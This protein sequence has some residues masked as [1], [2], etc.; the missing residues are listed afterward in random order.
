MFR[1]TSPRPLRPTVGNTVGLS[2][3][4]SNSYPISVAWTPRHR[5]R[6]L[7]P[8][9]LMFLTTPTDRSR[10]FF[11]LEENADRPLSCVFLIQENAD[12][13]VLPAVLL[14]SANSKLPTFEHRSSCSRSI[15]LLF[16]FPDRSV[17]ESAS[18]TFPALLQLSLQ[19]YLP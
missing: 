2:T 15:P 18:L 9:F 10:V 11:E 3:R 19:G 7:H 14:I 1:R 6:R 4:F 5:N 17:T 13:S 16:L 12:R 8:T